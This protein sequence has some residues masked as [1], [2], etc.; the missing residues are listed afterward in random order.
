MQDVLNRETTALPSPDCFH[1][2][3]SVWEGEQFLCHDVCSE[4]VRVILTVFKGEEDS[5]L[6]ADSSWLV[7]LRHLYD[8]SKLLHRHE[9]AIM[10]LV[11]LRCLVCTGVH[12]G[13]SGPA[14]KLKAGK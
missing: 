7:M 5:L 14:A 13:C 9:W 10:R 6:S 2:A 8:P 12:K 4:G 1:M 11:L 3:S